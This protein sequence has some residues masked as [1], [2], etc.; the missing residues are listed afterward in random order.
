[1]IGYFNVLTV[2][3]A[4]FLLVKLRLRLIGIVRIVG[5]VGYIR[6][7]GCI[8]RVWIV[9]LVGS[10]VVARKKQTTR[11]TYCQNQND[12]SEYSFLGHNRLLR[13]FCI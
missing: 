8:G 5:I 9:R 3:V 12:K 2:G 11:Q 4:L 7:I 13:N 10:V 1:M 6:R